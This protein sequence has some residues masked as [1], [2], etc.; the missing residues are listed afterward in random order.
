MVFPYTLKKIKDIDNMYQGNYV[1]IRGRIVGLYY[2]TPYTK[3]YLTIADGSG[4]VLVKIQN[5]VSQTIFNGAVVNIRGEIAEHEGKFYLK[6]KEISKMQAVEDGYQQLTEIPLIDENGLPDFKG[7][8]WVKPAW[9]TEKLLSLYSMALREER[10][11]GWI[12]MGVVLFLIAFL[13][14][15][16]IAILLFLFSFLLI[17]LGIITTETYIAGYE[18]SQQK[19]KS[20]NKAK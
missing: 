12:G 3:A 10:K 19:L 7:K 15:V 18:T 4:M 17:I 16:F 6:T 13:T 2:D 5:A 9:K 11:L 20:A 8:R 1:L 14:P